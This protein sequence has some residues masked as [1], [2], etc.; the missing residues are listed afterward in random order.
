MITI[1][2]RFTFDAAHFLPCMPELH[3]CR[4]MHGHTYEVELQLYGPPDANGILVDYEDIAKEWERIHALV[5]HKVLNDVPGLKMPS[6][7]VL[8]MWM[9]DQ[10]MQTPFRQLVSRIRVAES[11]TTWADVSARDYVTHRKSPL[12]EGLLSP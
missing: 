8:V 4:G 12:W 5:D 1:A 9:F 2:K 6:T 10:F 3:K 11:A 7:E